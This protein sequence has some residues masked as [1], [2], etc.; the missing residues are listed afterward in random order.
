MPSPV[1]ADRLLVGRVRDGD[2]GAWKEL[3]D[4]YEGRL[5][6]FAESR[7]G[8]KQSAEDVV[9]E[10]VAYLQKRFN[11]SV[12]SHTVREEHVN[13]PLPKELRLVH[14]G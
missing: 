13:F 3:I 8:Q 11:A 9:Q 6:A 7:L 14:A 12:A 2:E 1:E 10:C 4:R 5:L